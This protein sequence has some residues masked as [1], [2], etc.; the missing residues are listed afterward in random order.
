MDTIRGPLGLEKIEERLLE[1]KARDLEYYYNETRQLTDRNGQKRSA[2]QVLMGELMDTL[3]PLKND[4]LML[5]AHSM[6]TIIAYDVL[7]DLGQNDAEF[8]VHH[9]VTIGSPLGIAA[10]KAR[11]SKE[12]HDQ[13]RTPTVVSGKWRNYADKADPVSVDAHLRD[14]IGPNKRMVRVED[15]LVHNHYVDLAGKRKPHKSFGYLRTPELSDQ[16]KDFLGS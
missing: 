4:R 1:D 2:R 7:R 9:F 5:I 14:D 16:I 3:V 12:R 8:Q 13:T 10:V 11:I 6:G 15:D